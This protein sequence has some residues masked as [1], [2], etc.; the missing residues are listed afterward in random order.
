MKRPVE[1][2]RE[3]PLIEVLYNPAADFPALAYIG[4]DF[5]IDGSVTIIYIHL[6]TLEEM[7]DKLQYI[8]NQMA[9]EIWFMKKHGYSST[10]AIEKDPPF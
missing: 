1:D 4:Q 5:L 9:D 10:D 7:K 8:V 6:S 2:G 3:V